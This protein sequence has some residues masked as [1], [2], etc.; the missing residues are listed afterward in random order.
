MVLSHGLE[1]GPQA[2]K[3]GALAA[4]AEAQGWRTLRPDYRDLDAQGLAAAT[5]PRLARLR[6]AVPAHAPCV[7]VGSS[8]GAFISGL[9]SCEVPV[10]GLVFAGHAAADFPVT[11]RPSP[12]A[13]VVPVC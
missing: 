6:A 12:C 4:V 13:R 10:R 8:F 11:R 5:S 2:T 3:V 7:L 1:S 9:V